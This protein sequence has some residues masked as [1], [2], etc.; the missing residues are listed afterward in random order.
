MFTWLHDT[1]A[2]NTDYWRAALGG[3]ILLLV[4]LFPMGVAGFVRDLVQRRREAGSAAA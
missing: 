1:V 4:L 3:V 2:R